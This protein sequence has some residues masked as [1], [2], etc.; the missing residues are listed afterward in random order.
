[1][2]SREDKFISRTMFKSNISLTDG[3]SF[4]DLFTSIMNYRYGDFQ[5]IKPW[6]N[7]G[8]TKCD[9]N[10]FNKG[11]YSQVFAPEDIK[12]SYPKVVS[13]LN[14]DFLGLK[15]QW[16]DVR[17]FYFVVNDKYNGINADSLMEIK[18]I[19]QEYKLESAA[20]ITA[21]DLENYLFELNDDQIESIVGFI[22]DPSKIKV[23]DFNV[24]NEVIG[25]IMG[26]SLSQHNLAN[27]VYPDWNDKIEFNNLSDGIKHLLNSG[28]I[29]VSPLELYIKNNS[30]FLGDQLRNK[31]NEIYLPNKESLLGDDLFWAIVN[32][33][34]PNKRFDCQS[35][36]IVIMAKYFEAC[37]IFE[38]PVS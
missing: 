15:A 5:S 13:K 28:M 37:D 2:L 17:E 19:K 30:D 12:K 23:L 4:E 34:S 29:Q 35:A 3:Q 14:T 22:P 6:G 18:S 26:L 11:I 20:F 33:A 36:T 38:E 7:V 31:M 25:H 21:K 27:I 10:I 8:D 9:G 32:E 16:T 1:M 24:L